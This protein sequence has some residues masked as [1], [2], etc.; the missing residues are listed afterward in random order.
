MD[1]R[2]KLEIYNTKYSNKA[3]TFIEDAIEKYQQHGYNG[4]NDTVTQ[5]LEMIKFDE[6]IIET[7][8]DYYKN[9]KSMEEYYERCVSIIKIT[10]HIYSE[11]LLKNFSDFLRS[12]LKQLLSGEE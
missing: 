1:Y 5:C 8:H 9:E 4:F 10:R 6:K 2:D 12:E 7:Y 11:I 3:L